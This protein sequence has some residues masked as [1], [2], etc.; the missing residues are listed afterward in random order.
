MPAARSIKTHLI[1]GTTGLAVCGGQSS[2]MGTDKSLLLYHDKP[3][4]YHLYDMLQPFC[5]TVFISCNAEQAR[6]MEPGYDLLPDHPS[7]SNTGPMAALLSAY[8]EFPGKNILFIGCD[9]P[10]L[11]GT[12]LRQFSEYCNGLKPVCFYNE[13]SAVYEPLLAWYPNESFEPLKKMQEAGE[14]SLQHFL[15]SSQAVKFYPGSKR[16]IISIDTHEDFIKAS[17]QLFHERLTF[18]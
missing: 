5:E 6:N 4:R 9:Y 8:K 12:H 7:Y 1:P 14:Y 11:T 13:Q 16:S 18:F 17:T 2:R 10:F 15:I 3:Q